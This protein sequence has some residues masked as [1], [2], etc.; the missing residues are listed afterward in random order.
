MD[1]PQILLLEGVLYIVVF[2]GMS[3]LRQEGF[4]N[5]SA[6]EVLVL[7]L[8][9]AGTTWLT[10]FRLNP[11]IML[12]VIYLISMR[13]RLLVDFGNLLARQGRFPQAEILYTWACRLWPDVA[14]REIV[15]LN[16][17]TSLL[18]QGKQEEAAA[19]FTA[20]L[21]RSNHNRLGDKYRAAAHYNL[22]VAYRKL[23]NEVQARS[24]FNTVLNLLPISEYG[25]M[26]RRALER[27]N[28]A[29]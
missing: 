23:G 4:S 24:E 29:K 12:V 27:G 16:R 20:F 19:A 5:Q 1:L 9:I 18:F 14:G 3:L 21:E 25:R 10:G 8:V 17:A 2:Q 22:G 28:P 6:L 15:L 13:T 11:V 26:A 7:T